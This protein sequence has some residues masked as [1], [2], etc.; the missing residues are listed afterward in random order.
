MN[1]H[2]SFKS[3]KAPEIDRDIQ[4]HVHKLE[5]Y[6]HVFRP[7]LIHLH[8]VL[9]NGRREGPTASLNLRLPTGQLFSSETGNTHTAALKNA[10]SDLVQQLKK[11]KELLRNEHKWARSKR[12]P[13]AFAGSESAAERVTGEPQAA[14]QGNGAATH[15]EITVATFTDDNRNL[16][17]ADVRSYINANLKKLERFI[18]REIR[19]RENSGQLQPSRVSP[20]EV[21]DEVV[22]NALSA[23]EQPPNVSLERWL[24]RLAIRTMQQLSRDDYDDPSSVHLED[25][26][27]K[28]NVSGTDDEILQYHQPGER[29]SGEDIIADLRAATPE[30]LAANDEFIDQL[31]NSLQGAQP[32]QREAFIL[33]AIEG[34]SA[35]EIAQITDHEPSQVKA[36]IARA[37]EH[38]IKKLPPTNAL[39]QILLKRTQVA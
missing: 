16:F 27:G 3:A 1:L 21:L 25:P 28:Q 5:R 30:E 17:Q 37:R 7:E 29:L 36:A 19:Y 13:R 38:L 32:L 23:E 4:Q 31:E 33:Y 6:L 14:R 2:F 18:E 15:E 34:F 9:D 22:M 10:F 12:A 20:E 11:H 24:Y 26:V 35:T 8:G 39:K